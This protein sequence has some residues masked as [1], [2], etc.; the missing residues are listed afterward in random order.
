MTYLQLC[1]RVRREMGYAGTGPSTVVAQTGQ[2]Q[3]AATFSNG[4]VQDVTAS[5]TWGTSNGAIATITSGGV[6][7]AA[8]AGSVTI[9]CT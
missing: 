9:T 6:V 2:M 1:Q 3:A 7:T 4:A 5:A 8:A